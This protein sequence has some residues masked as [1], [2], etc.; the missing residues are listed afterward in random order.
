MQDLHRI[1]NCI[2]HIRVL[3]SCGAAFRLSAQGGPQ[4]LTHKGQMILNDYLNV[5][6]ESQQDRLE[7]KSG[8]V[9]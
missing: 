2:P 6:V 3:K 5:F 1:N 7:I 8:K 9:N 4:T